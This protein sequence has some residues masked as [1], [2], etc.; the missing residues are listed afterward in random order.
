[1]S[2]PIVITGDTAE[3]PANCFPGAT[4]VAPLSAPMA[5]SAKFK[6]GNMPACIAGDEGK[7]S[8]PCQYFTPAFSTPGAGTVTIESLIPPQQSGVATST[9]T[10]AIL[11][12]GKFIAKLAV[13]KPAQLDTPTGPQLDPLTTYVGTGEFKTSNKK[14]TTSR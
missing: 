4:L 7:V 2:A 13:S 5:G 3:F 10:A 8:L 9:S 6:V 11:A 1:M 14:A 12:T